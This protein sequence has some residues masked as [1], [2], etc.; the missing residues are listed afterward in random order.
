MFLSRS[1]LVIRVRAEG[2]KPESGAT[3]PH[4]ALDSGFGAARRPRMTWRR[5]W[6]LGR[7]AA[8]LGLVEELVQP[9]DR[10]RATGVFGDHAFE[11]EAV[12]VVHILQTRQ[13][14]GD[15]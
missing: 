9:L 6:G 4:S 15:G 2:A 1:I 13:T 11:V 10:F 7:L 14:V 5:I 3:R 8:G 12:V